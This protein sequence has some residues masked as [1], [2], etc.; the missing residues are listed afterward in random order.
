MSYFVTGGTGFIGRYVL[1]RLL[2]RKGRI[3]VLVRPQSKERM[4]AVVERLGAPRGRIVQL[5]GDIT[6]PNLGLSKA[7]RDKLKDVDHFLHLGA[8][9]DITASDQSNRET[10]VGGT[11]NAVRLATRRTKR[12]SIR[13]ARSPSPGAT[14]ACSART[15]STRARSRVPIRPHQVRIRT[16]RS[17]RGRPKRIYRPAV[18][19]GDSKTGAID[20]V[21]GPYLIFKWLKRWP[22]P[23]SRVAP[24]LRIPAAG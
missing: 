22:R 18:V 20:K 15:C 6:E 8:I 24:D 14:T 23:P 12:P 2:E 17:R 5:T 7:D 16:D 3:Y 19:V 13:S 9:Y 11:I 1:E 21:D 4:D 10:N